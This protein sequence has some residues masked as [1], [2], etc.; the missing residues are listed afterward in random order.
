MKTKP[1]F[2]DAKVYSMLEEIESNLLKIYGHK[3]KKI[4]LYGS[5]ARGEQVPGSDLD[6]MVLLSMDEEDY[7]E[8]RE[9]VLDLSVELTTRYGIVIS[10]QENNIDFFN[11]WSD[12][13][14]FFHNVINEGVELYGK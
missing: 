12:T 9:K 10:I 14:P 3:L 2:G 5:Y 11:E 4:I 13:L 8:Y 1:E 7:R 6:V